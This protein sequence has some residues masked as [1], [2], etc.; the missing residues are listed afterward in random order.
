MCQ[1]H[2][3]YFIHINS[4]TTIQEENIIITILKIAKLRH[5]E[6]Q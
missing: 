2:S 5:V 6:I 1:H 3:K 4:L